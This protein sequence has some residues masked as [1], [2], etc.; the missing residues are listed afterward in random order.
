MASKYSDQEKIIC[1]QKYNSHQYDFEF[2]GAK[3]KK[4]NKINLQLVI[5]VNI[6]KIKNIKFLSFFLFYGNI[7][8]N[9]AYIIS[10]R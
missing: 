8:F 1:N 10:V 4:R 6:L 2:E 5:F 3:Y 9:F 7:F